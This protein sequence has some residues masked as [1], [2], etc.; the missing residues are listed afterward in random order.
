VHA[1][2]VD[3]ANAPRNRGVS[4]NFIADKEKAAIGVADVSNI[5]ASVWAIR[6]GKKFPVREERL[7]STKKIPSS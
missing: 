2:C 4:E 5:N 1:D 6:K 7:K 3:A